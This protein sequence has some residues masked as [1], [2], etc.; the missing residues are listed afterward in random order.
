MQRYSAA[1]VELALVQNLVET[2]GEMPPTRGSAFLQQVR[3]R[4]QTWEETT[5]EVQITPSQF[6]Q[7]T[8]LDPEPVF[9]ELSSLV[10]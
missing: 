10:S 5:V 7:I 8:G 3:D 6:F 2:W 4:L 1:A 9:G